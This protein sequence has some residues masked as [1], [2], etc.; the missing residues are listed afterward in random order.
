MRPV[1]VGRAP[2][3]P[4]DDPEAEALR[5]PSPNHDISRTHLRIEPRGWQIEVTD[6][7]STNGTLVT[8]PDGQTRRLTPGQPSEVGLGWTIDIGDGQKILL[9]PPD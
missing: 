5:V 3:V 9:E 2:S 4:G 7:N 1:V 8:S 6:L